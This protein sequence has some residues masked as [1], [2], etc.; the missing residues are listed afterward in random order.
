MTDFDPRELPR[1]ELF[2]TNA[3][4]NLQEWGWIRN[5]APP[6][7]V[8][9]GRGYNWRACWRGEEV[10]FPGTDEGFAAAVAWR[11][12]REAAA[13]AEQQLHQLVQD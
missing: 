8:S 3:L 1:D 4:Y 13:V 12:A 11:K 9:R 2:M 6:V 5:N 7:G 10:Y